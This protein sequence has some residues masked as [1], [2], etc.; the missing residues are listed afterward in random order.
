M[1]TMNVP[2]LPHHP[3]DHPGSLKILLGR[4]ASEA[5]AAHGDQFFAIIGHPDCTSPPEAAGR[6]VLT[7]LPLSRDV[8]NDASRVALGRATAKPIKAPNKP[9]STP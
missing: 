8:L 1:P 2:I 5:L 4:A 9:T 6:M 7:C 3:L